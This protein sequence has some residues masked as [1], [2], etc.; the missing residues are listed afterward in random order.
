[1]ITID[2]ANM[3]FLGCLA[4]GGILLLVSVLLGDV[5]GGVFDWLN[6]DLDLGGVSLLPILL[7]FVAMFGVGGLFGTEGLGMEAAPA[8]LVGAA[9]GAVGSLVV[10]V[11]FRGLRSAEAPGATQS[12]SLI[13]EVGQ[14]T[15]GIAPNHYGTVVVRFDGAP[16]QRRATAD[17][18]IASGRRVRVIALVGGD[19]VVAPLEQSAA[20]VD[21]T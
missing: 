21:E 11:V 12:E 10:F 7:G 6:V 5:L 4:V 8:S 15:V 17:E 2:I 19:L 13:G 14:V 18:A 3:I 1:M 20:P 9:T 16:M